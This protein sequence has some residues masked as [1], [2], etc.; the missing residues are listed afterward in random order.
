MLWKNFGVTRY[1]RVVFYDYD[2]IE[3][4]TDCKFRRIP[5]APDFET[6]MSGEVWY[7]VSRQDVFPEEFATFLLVSDRIRDGVHAHHADL[8][9]VAFWHERAGADSPRQG[10]GFLSLSGISAFLQLYGG[11]KPN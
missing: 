9:D 10:A 7:S 8:F 2:E 6:E 4:M 1:G 3:Y 5:P 11:D